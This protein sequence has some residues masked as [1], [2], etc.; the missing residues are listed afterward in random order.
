MTFKIVINTAIH[1]ASLNNDSPSSFIIKCSGALIELNT[2]LMPIGSVAPN[3]LPNN[4]K[5]IKE[6]S[7]TNE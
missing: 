1:M 5:T 6:L 3:A 2:P 7:L 4:N